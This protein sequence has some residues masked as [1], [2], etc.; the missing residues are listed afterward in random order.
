M[1]DQKE[2]KD[3]LFVELK[4]IDDRIKGLD[5]HVKNIDEQ[6]DELNSS[7]TVINNFK[8]L[9]EGEELRV[10]LAPGVYFDAKL[11]NTNKLMANIGSGVLVEKFPDEIIAIMDTQIE[12][13][14]NY[15]EK[16][17]GNMKGLIK[18]AENI[19]REIE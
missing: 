14:S 3:E 19:Q 8:E 12:E 1:S 6:I 18:R 4:E 10:P 15:R 11:D 2:G 7:K 9:K 13:L 5:N 17:I 16:L